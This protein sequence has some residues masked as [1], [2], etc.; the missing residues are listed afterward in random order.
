MVQP[1]EGKRSSYRN[2]LHDYGVCGRWNES[3]DPQV[4]C[5]IGGDLYLDQVAFDGTGKGTAAGFCDCYGKVLDLPGSQ[6]LAD[7]IGDRCLCTARPA[8][9]KRT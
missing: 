6:N 9:F 8:D 7:L 1:L 2:S 4:A 5:R 3:T